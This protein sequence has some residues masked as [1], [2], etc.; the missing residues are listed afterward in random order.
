MSSLYLVAAEVSGDL[1]GASLLRALKRDEPQFT[2]RGVGGPAMAAEGFASQ[3]PMSDLAVFGFASV[4]ARFPQLRARLR[5]T[6]AE[7]LRDPPVAVILIDSYGFSARVARRVRAVRPEIPIIKYV[8]PQVWA[9]RPGRARTMR[10]F[11]DHILALFPFEPAVH[12]ELGGPK[13]TYVG[14]PL[15]EQLSRLRPDEE[16]QRRRESGTPL[17]LVMPGS[18]RSELGHLAATFGDALAELSRLHGEA[19]F[20]LPALPHLAAEVEAAVAQWR[21][22]PRIVFGDDEKYRAMRS[23]RFAIVA[24]GTASLELA[25]ARV[26]HVG[27]YRVRAWE[28]FVL[29]RLIRISNALLPNI[30]LSRN[31]VPELLQEHCTVEAIVREAGPLW[32]DERA[33][34]SQADA[35][36]E[37]DAVLE[38]AGAP[39]SQRAAAAVR[40]IVAKREVS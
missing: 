11:F 27:A 28:A 33:R 38:T 7:I 16:E 25:L 1:L 8:S 30:L 18:R 35:F 39:P 14:H 22:Q 5:E 20:V 32:T 40:E 26:P 24:S 4:I 36:R 29:R 37:L 6:V 34:S 2:F 19:E 3:F 31:V 15:M 12:R 9:W 21:V 17:V 10:A 13:C 23:A